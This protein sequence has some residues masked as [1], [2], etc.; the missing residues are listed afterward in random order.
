ME[1]PNMIQDVHIDTKL[2]IYHSQKTIQKIIP[3]E[4]QIILLNNT[5]TGVQK[6]PNLAIA[7]RKRKDPHKIVPEI[8]QHLKAGV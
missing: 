7:D 1:N 6:N 3:E 4:D 8:N 2:L 5:K